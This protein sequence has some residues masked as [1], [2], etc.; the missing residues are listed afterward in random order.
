MS[1]SLVGSEMCIRDRL[2]S[3][4]PCARVR[5]RA[6]ARS[7]GGNKPLGSGFHLDF[8]LLYTSDAADDM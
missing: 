2:A 4:G 6:E 5:V 7:D 8:C 1:A 3:R